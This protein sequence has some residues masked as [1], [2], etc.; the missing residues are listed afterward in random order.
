MANLYELTKQ[1]GSIY[2]FILN[3]GWW[4]NAPY[5]MSKE[6]SNDRVVKAIQLVLCYGRRTLPKYIDEHD[7]LGDII[8]QST[9]N[10][11]RH[12]TIIKNCYGSTYIFY[13]FPATGS[14]PFGYT[15]KENRKKYGDF[16]Y[17][18][19]DLNI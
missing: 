14:D 5:Y 8:Y 18:F 16:C 11:V 10:F 12:K 15:S 1:T 6:C 17:K 19:S 4:A 2:N 9:R 7:C 3:G 13:S